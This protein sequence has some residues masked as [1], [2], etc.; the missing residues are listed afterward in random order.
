MRIS[1][2]IESNLGYSADQIESPMNLG[3]LLEAV[4]MAIEEWGEDAVV[5]IH[6]MNNRYGANFGQIASHD[7]FDASDDDEDDEN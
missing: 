4:E 6:Q 1:M 7:V 5:V 2:N 3:D